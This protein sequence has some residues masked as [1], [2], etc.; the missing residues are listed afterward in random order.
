MYFDDKNRKSMS[1]G[2]LGAK[3]LDIDDPNG[4]AKYPGFDDAR[5]WLAELNH[6]DRY[7]EYKRR[8]TGQPPDGEVE[9]P[10]GECSGA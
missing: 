10:D 6:R 3:N 5:Q 2:W 1:M 7:A 9:E 4:R 8:G